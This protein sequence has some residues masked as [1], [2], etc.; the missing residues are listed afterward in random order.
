MHDATVL[1]LEKCRTGSSC[2]TS[3]TREGRKTLAAVAGLTAEAHAAPCNEAY[4]LVQGGGSVPWPTPRGAFSGW[5]RI[6][7]P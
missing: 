1:V 3:P 2:A 6:L 7:P 5:N 4:A